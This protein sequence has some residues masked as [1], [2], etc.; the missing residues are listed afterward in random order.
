MYKLPKKSKGDALTATDWNNHAEAIQDAL[1]RSSDFNTMIPSVPA[2]GHW[3]GGRY[4]DNKGGFSLRS[5]VKEGGRWVAYFNPGRV[6]EIHAGGAR[7]IVP[8]IGGTKMNIIPYP[9]LKAE[10]GKVYLDLVWGNAAHDCITEAVI[11]MEQS[12]SGGRAV[13]LTLGEFVSGAGSSGSS[14]DD[15][16]YKPHLTGCITYAANSLDEGW[17]VLVVRS[18]GGNEGV[19]VK[20]GDI[21]ING[22]LAHEGSGAWEKAAVNEGDLWLHVICDD[23][24]TYKSHDVAASKAAARPLETIRDEDTQEGGEYYFKLATVTTLPE[25]L[26]DD[27]NAPDLVAVKQYVLGSV[28]CALKP[29]SYILKTDPKCALELKKENKDHILTLNIE[30]TTED[31]SVTSDLKAWLIQEQGQND[32]GDGEGPVKLGVRIEDGRPDYKGVDP[33]N[34]AERDISLKLDTKVHSTASGIKYGLSVEA[35]ELAMMLEADTAPPL[36]ADTYAGEDPIHVDGR[37][38]KLKVNTE[39]HSTVNGIKYGLIQ[40]GPQLDITID[41][42]DMS[43]NGMSALMPLEVTNNQLNLRYASYWKT[44]SLGKGIRTRLY[45]DNNFLAV[46]LDVSSYEAVSRVCDSWTILACNTDYAL[47]PQHTPDGDIY[48]Q[49]ARWDDISQQYQ[50]IN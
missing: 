1:N 19:Y 46:D 25:P 21:Y 48:I 20:Q 12:A 6:A 34:I 9:G 45:L 31:L 23:K 30:S 13:R 11:T 15:I 27:G 8:K 36:D 2:S 29:S 14:I 43:G 49:Q 4:A 37:T 17:R 18:G 47:R 7:V 39:V 40:S 50:P 5:L 24:G 10:V 22:T 28:T 33:I 41:A 38:I 26:V 32:Q 3:T 44:P 42:T 35:G 16:A